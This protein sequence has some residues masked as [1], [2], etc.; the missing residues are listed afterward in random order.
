MF[1]LPMPIEIIVGITMISMPTPFIEFFMG[2]RFENSIITPNLRFY[3]GF[4]IS[5]LNTLLQSSKFL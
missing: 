1:F 3:A 2:T 5:Y 4:W